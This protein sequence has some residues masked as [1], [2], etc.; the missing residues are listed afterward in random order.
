MKIVND[1]AVQR[2]VVACV[3]C[4]EYAR[5]AEAIRGALRLLGRGTVF[6]SKRV[7]LKV[8]LM[9]G[10]PAEQ[11]INTNPEFVGALV[12]VVREQGGEALVADSTGV[13]GCTDEAFEAS[14]IADAVRHEGGKLINFDACELTHIPIDGKVLREAWVP[15]ILF[16]ANLVVTV[17][18]LKTHTIMTMT[19]ALKNQVGVLP[20]G[21]KCRLHEL[22]P[23]PRK[24][25]HAILDLHSVLPVRMAIVDA[26]IGLSGQGMRRA[27]VPRKVGA[28]V[29]GEDLVAVDS[30]CADLIG[31]TPRRVLTCR[32]GQTRGFGVGDLSRIDVCEPSGAGLL[33]RTPIQFDKAGFEPKRIGPFARYFYKIRGHSVKPHLDA[34]RCEKC[35]RCAKGCPVH[36]IAMSPLPVIGKSCIRCYRC[37]ENCPPGAM[38]LRCH[39]LLRKSFR[40]RAANMDIRKLFS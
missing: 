37:H 11:A 29:A 17:P 3:G 31:M 10:A 5:S 25:A 32:L 40:K 24:L 26:I 16:D 6:R 30:V 38:G 15:K 34:A 23:T 18:K 22:A 27:A 35:G 2:S 14:G 1:A 13:L 12:R 28:V 36:A 9:K 7:L 19:C 4:E 33:A 8:N 39:P 20:G 21:H